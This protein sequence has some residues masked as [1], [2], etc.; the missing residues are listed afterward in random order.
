LTPSRFFLS[1]FVIL[2]GCATTASAVRSAE[3]DDC[4]GGDLDACVKWGDSE[5]THGPTG[6]RNALIAYQ[7]GCTLNH[8][9]SCARLAELFG[10]SNANPTKVRAALQTACSGGEQ[11]ACVELGR[12]LSRRK[13]MPYFAAA[14]DAGVAEGCAELASA[15]RSTW[16]L[17]DYL[18]KS[19]E[20]DEKA[21][22]LG[23]RPGCV[24]AG[25]AY[26]FG[27]GVP[28]DTAKG[29]K[30]L[31]STCDE[32]EASGCVLLAKIY[33]EGIGVPVDLKRS[34]TY[35]QTAS[36]QAQAEE[37]NTAQS[38]FVV[39][40]DGCNRGDPLGCFNSAVMLN[41]GVEVDR[42][43]STAREFFSQS[44][45]AGCDPACDQM[46]HIRVRTKTVNGA[47][48]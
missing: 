29:L 36:S 28:A 2:A 6:R 42:N 8:S 27:S 44:C 23:F 3:H 15:Y 12:G 48:K 30:Y 25:Q 41:E 37:I 1:F 40:V 24:G 39:Y 35:Y 43:I 16:Q 33:E 10:K 46:K 11:L 9:A 26:L 7:F 18:R 20:L 45:D 34:N 31:E 47:S 5:I 17:G 21:C 38:A 32:R 19:V 14:C 4:I 13:G 22:E